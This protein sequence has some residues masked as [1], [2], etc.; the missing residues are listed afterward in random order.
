VNSKLGIQDWS[1]SVILVELPRRPQEHD[2]LQRVIEMVRKR[3]DCSV[4]VD[5]SRV[6]VAGCTTLTRLLE[7]RQLLLDRKHML[8]LC[9]VAPATKGVFTVT[10]LDEILHFVKDK[11]AALAQFDVPG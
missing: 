11:F 2:E 5:F 10:R 9:S 1:K 8:V 7:L 3:C 4:V 6:D